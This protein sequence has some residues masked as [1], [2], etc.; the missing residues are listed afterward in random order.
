[1][2]WNIIQLL[3]KMKFDDKWMKLETLLLSEVTQTLRQ[4]LHVFSYVWMSPSKL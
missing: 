1:M 2:K 3:N 4:I